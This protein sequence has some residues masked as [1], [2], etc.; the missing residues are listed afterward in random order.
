M[1]SPFPETRRPKILS[2]LDFVARA[3]NSTGV[4]VEKLDQ[5][6]CFLLYKVA[7]IQYLRRRIRGV[8]PHIWVL[9][10]PRNP[11]GSINL[12]WGR[13]NI[14]T[15]F[16]LR[17]AFDNYLASALS[18][19]DATWQLLNVAFQLN[20]S[21]DD[22]RLA[23]KTIAALRKLAVGRST[24]LERYVQLK[25][26][27][28]SWLSELREARNAATHRDLLDFRARVDLRVQD[29]PKQQVLAIVG[30]QHPGGRTERLDLFLDRTTR[31]TIALLE[32]TFMQLAQRFDDMAR[33]KESC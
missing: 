28:A 21:I 24:G 17:L 12:S 22:G 33:R 31:E 2:L 25:G 16:Q 7:G 5:A 8:A 4:H 30:V 18:V 14:E 20:E 3:R 11:D 23:D 6:E 19:W 32:Y 1:N 27:S 13:H 15:K 10:L 26:D 9:E 29:L